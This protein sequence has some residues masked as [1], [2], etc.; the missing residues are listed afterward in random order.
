MFAKIKKLQEFADRLI[1]KAGLDFRPGLDG[2][3]QLHVCHSCYAEGA[4]E[5]VHLTMSRIWSM[6]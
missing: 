3:R 1:R 2:K 5:T 4:L 6:S